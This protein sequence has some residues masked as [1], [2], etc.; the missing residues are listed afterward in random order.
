MSPKSR[1]PKGKKG[2]KGAKGTAGS[3]TETV[4]E[5]TGGVPFGI[6][7]LGAFVMSLPAIMGFVEGTMPFDET[8][9]RFLAA[10][11]VAWLLSHLVYAVA[12]SFLKEGPNAKVSETRTT[13]TFSDGGFDPNMFASSEQR[14]P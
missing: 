3:T 14:T 6:V 13:E 5:E 9:L 8:C 1:P 12:A 2:K 7:V 10:L 4:V 11:A